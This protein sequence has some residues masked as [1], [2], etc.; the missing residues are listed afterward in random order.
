M[1]LLLL[2][3]PVMLLVMLLLQTEADGCSA[4]VCGSEGPAQ[5]MAWICSSS[6][7]SS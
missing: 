6:S 7:S 4:E 5:Q 2:L 3:L 1:Q